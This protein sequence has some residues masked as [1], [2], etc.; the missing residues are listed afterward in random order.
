MI[1]LGIV[2]PPADC[3]NVLCFA[4][5]LLCFTGALISAAAGQMYTREHDFL[6][7]TLR[8]IPPLIFSTGESAKLGL[9]FRSQSIF[10][11]SA[12]ETKQNMEDILNR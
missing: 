2:R 3:R 9:S 8:L 1:K 6:T 5:V 12:F 11:R 4:R 7:Q 10:T